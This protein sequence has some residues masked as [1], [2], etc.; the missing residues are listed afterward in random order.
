MTEIEPFKKDDLRDFLKCFTDIRL[1]DLVIIGRTDQDEEELRYFLLQD[2]RCVV[3]TIQGKVNPQDFG[4]RVKVYTGTNWFGDTAVCIVMDNPLW[5]EVKDCLKEV[6]LSDVACAIDDN[7]LR[8]RSVFFCGHGLLDGSLLLSD[9]AVSFS[10]F[11]G[12][13]FPSKDW[14]D[15]KSSLNLYLNCCFALRI[16]TLMFPDNPLGGL[17]EVALYDELRSLDGENSLKEDEQ[18]L[19]DVVN[20]LNSALREKLPAI[21]SRNGVK[22]APLGFGPMYGVGNIEIVLRGLM[23]RHK[24]N[25]PPQPKCVTVRFK[26]WSLEDVSNHEL[27][28]RKEDMLPGYVAEPQF[29]TFEARRGDSFLLRA[30]TWSLLVDGGFGST[31]CFWE[32]VHRLSTYDM[33]LTHSDQD[34]INGLVFAVKA[35][36]LRQKGRTLPLPSLVKFYVATPDTVGA[37]LRT[38][39]YAR[40]L[41]SELGPA[42]CAYPNEPVLEINAGNDVKVR[43]IRVIPS[44]G[45]AAGRKKSIAQYL[46]EHLQD[47]KGCKWANETCLV[48]VIEI[49]YGSLTKRV[50]F[51]G[52]AFGH[53]IAAGLK[54][55]SAAAGEPLRSAVQLDGTLLVDVMNVP[56]HGSD[57]NRF[58]DLLK[59]CRAKRYVVSTNDDGG[60]GHPGPEVCK[61]LCKE[62]RSAGA[63]V[64][65]SYE[66]CAKKLAPILSPDLYETKVSFGN[67][68]FNV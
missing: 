32:T 45:A 52:D 22:C 26:N 47:A 14:I 60:F 34:H 56:H 44:E 31:P 54:K 3:S 9:Q 28:H 18:R 27:L 17:F 30:G 62:I 1:L 53:D 15:P 40:S 59:V 35:E 50:L 29:Q 41:A 68:P 7:M 46:R 42:H 20:S 36:I 55:K 6:F 2:A 51:T 64:H 25:S 13:V 61:L 5:A 19:Q 48:S 8:T 24:V 57:N 58:G 66:K 12:A 16:A 67:I 10:E 33:L 63:F 39:Q 43:L 11:R 65:F 37:D 38:W 21:V 49:S 4:K 23:Y